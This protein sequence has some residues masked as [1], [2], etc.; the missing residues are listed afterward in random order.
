M[1]RRAVSLALAAGGLALAAWSGA[2][3]AGES[4]ARRVRGSVPIRILVGGGRGK[5]TLVRLACAGLRAEGV[6]AAGRTT[7]DEPMLHLPDLGS[8]PVPRRGVANVREMRR[9]LRRAAARGAG[10]AV[11]ENMAVAAD[12]QAVVARRL[13]PP[14][15]AAF[16]PDARD[17]LEAWPADA[18][19]RA[20][21]MLS[22]L[23]ASVPAIVPAQDEAFAEAA[24]RLGRD[25]VAADALDDERLRRP[26]SRVLAGI[27]LRVVEHDLGRAVDPGPIAAEAAAREGI[28]VRRVGDAAWVDLLS[29]NDA[30]ST[31]WWMRALGGGR[32][33]PSTALYLNRRDRVPRLADFARVLGAGG[34][35]SI[36]GDPAPLRA[37]GLRPEAVLGASTRSLEAFAAA[38]GGI[39]FLVGNS[40]GFGRVARAWLAERGGGEEL[41]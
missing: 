4:R 9:D 29:V 3:L 39:V 21:M 10:A 28:R 6:A 11:F 12:L 26:H 25:V 23:P 37:L 22:A 38:R 15:V 1:A 16:A 31:W 8:V 7:G 40:G 30:P 32:G 18:T 36:A 19:E 2:G 35:W 24:R 13:F 17:H 5:S 14:T 27:A 41:W 34:G 20:A 33:E